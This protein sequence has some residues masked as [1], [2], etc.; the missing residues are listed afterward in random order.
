MEGSSTIP[1]TEG[2]NKDQVHASGITMLLANV[3]PGGPVSCGV[4]QKLQSSMLAKECSIMDCS[5]S[6]WVSLRLHW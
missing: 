4:Y 6:F 2:R 3:A 1:I 5:S